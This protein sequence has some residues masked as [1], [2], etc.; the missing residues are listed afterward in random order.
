MDPLS[1]TMQIINPKY[2][3]S[4]SKCDLGIIQ[5]EFGGG[6]GGRWWR[7]ISGD[8]WQVTN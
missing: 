6:G 8:G 5:S 1:R 2:S 4:T 7:G 3:Y